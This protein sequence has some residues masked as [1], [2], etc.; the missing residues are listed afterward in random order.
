MSY[1]GRRSRAA[2]RQ[3]SRWVTGISLQCWERHGWNAGPGQLYWLWRDRKGLVGNLLA[4]AANLL[5]AYGAATW[6]VATAGHQIWALG[7]LVVVALA[8]LGVAWAAGAFKSEG[9]GISLCESID[10]EDPS[11]L[12]GLPLIKLCAVLRRV[13]YRIP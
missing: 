7:V 12:I 3:R 4:P 6:L 11:A 2:V 10:S 5:A 9:L 1:V 13:G 8:G